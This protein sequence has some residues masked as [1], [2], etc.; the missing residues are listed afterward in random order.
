MQDL[1]AAVMTEIKLREELHY[2]QQTQLE[3]K[4]QKEDVD[5]AIIAEKE[6]NTLKSRFMSMISHE[7]RMPLAV[8][9]PSA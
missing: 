5:K 7:F 2:H 9:I 3:L 8:I 4:Q 1:V 6:L